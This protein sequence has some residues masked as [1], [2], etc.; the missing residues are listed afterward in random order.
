MYPLAATAIDFYKAGHI[1][2]YPAGTSL[3]YSN[4]TCR[5]DSNS[6]MPPE[7]DHRVV[8]FGL[9]GLCRWLFQ[10]LWQNTFFDRTEREVVEAYR[11]RMHDSLGPDRDRCDHILALHRIGHLPILIKALPEGSRVPLRV[12]LLTIRNTLPSFYWLTNFLE[13]QISA[14]LWKPIRNA[15]LAYWLRRLLD[16]MAIRT[17]SPPASVFFQGHDFSFRGMSGLHDAASSGCGHL[18]SFLGTDTVAAVD[19]AESYYGGAPG[20]PIGPIG[21]SVPATEHSVMCMSGEAGEEDLIRHLITE[22]YPRGIVSIVSDSWDFWQVLTRFVPNLMETIRHRGDGATGL[23]KVVFRPDSGV[24]KHIICGDPSAPDGSPE[25]RGALNI[26]WDI[27]GGTT[28]ATGHRLLDSHV[29]LIYGDSMS[30]PVVKDILQNME[31]SGFASANVVF[32]VG[33]W[34]YQLA[35]RDCFGCAMKSTYGEVDGVGRAIYKDPATDSNH[36]KRSARGLLRVDRDGDSFVA[37]DLQSWEQEAGGELKPVFED[38]KMLRHQTL[39][40]IRLR[41]HG[42]W[43]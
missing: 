18:L 3:I 12:P 9:Q 34:T 29:G 33:S 25:R 28:T 27:F 32:G 2:Q 1:D 7:F 20:R 10:D 13:T 15:T 24:P 26:L 11:H 35:T 42:G 31:E 21:C 41:L 22:V 17:G 40:E 38:G 37:H 8:F 30:Y 23:H 4:F 19:Y 39:D 14:E 43:L 6:G 5:S 16:D 36:I